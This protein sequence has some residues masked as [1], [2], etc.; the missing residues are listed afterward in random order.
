MYANNSE[1]CVRLD[2]SRSMNRGTTAVR[3]CQSLQL[4]QKLR[5]KQGQ[6][7]SAPGLVVWAF[8]AVMIESDLLL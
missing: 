3:H 2:N 5:V 6:K 7:K 4:L 8:A 1:Q